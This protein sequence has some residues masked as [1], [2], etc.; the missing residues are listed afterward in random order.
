MVSEPVTPEE[1]VFLQH[2]M[3]LHFSFFPELP[4]TLEGPSCCP[5]PPHVPLAYLSL[6]GLS[7]PVSPSQ[8]ILTYTV[9]AVQ[10]KRDVLQEVI[11]L[12]LP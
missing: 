9:P 2:P 5:V 8:C 10:Q 4:C 1:G 3:H 11:V 7:A 12:F 6:S